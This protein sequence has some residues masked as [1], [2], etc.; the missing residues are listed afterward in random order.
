M[1]LGLQNL[2][3]NIEAHDWIIDVVGGIG[4]DSWSD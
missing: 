2:V 3:F 4:F 1:K